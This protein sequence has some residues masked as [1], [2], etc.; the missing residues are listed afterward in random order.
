[1]GGHVSGRVDPARGRARGRIGPLVAVLRADLERVHGGAASR[2]PIARRIRGTVIRLEETFA[3]GMRFDF[4]PD[5]ELT[6]LRAHG[7]NAVSAI[8]LTIDEALRPGLDPALRWGRLRL[9]ADLIDDLVRTVDHIGRR[10]REIEAGLPAEPWSGTWAARLLL[11]AS[12]LLPSERRRAFLEDQ[13]GNLAQ[14]ESRREWIGYLAGV[15]WHMPAIAAATLAAAE[16][17][18]ES[19]AGWR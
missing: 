17:E 16:R 10:A 2:D 8:R 9:A 12:A 3:F 11:V 15:V 18:P 4:A 14:A 5:A 1:M 13:C 7:R 6:L 19:S